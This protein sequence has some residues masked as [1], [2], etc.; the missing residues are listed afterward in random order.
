MFAL[1]AFEYRNTK[2]ESL[3]MV[4]GFGIDPKVISMISLLTRF[5]I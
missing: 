5:F 1:V 2:G 4:S 3:R